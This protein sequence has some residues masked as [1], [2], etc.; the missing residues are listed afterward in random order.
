MSRSGVPFLETISKPTVPELTVE[1][2]TP[3]LRSSEALEILWDS[4]RR[5][6]SAPSMHESHSST[7][8]CSLDEVNRP[9]TRDR[10]S[11]SVPLSLDA[12]VLTKKLVNLSDKFEAKVVQM[13]EKERSRTLNG[14]ETPRDIPQ[15]TKPKRHSDLVEQWLRDSDKL[16]P[17]IGSPV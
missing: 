12:V 9:L 17:K 8:T 6:L 10:R 15:N 13:R 14:C 5:R 16:S 11:Q 7:S 4:S 1:P 2:P 3:K